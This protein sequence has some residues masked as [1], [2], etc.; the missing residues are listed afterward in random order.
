MITHVE[1]PTLLWAQVLNDSKV[2]EQSQ[3]TVRLAEVCPTAC[4]VQG[5]IDMN[6]V[7]K[8]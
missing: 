8:L 3:I 5:S 2:E 6:K 4:A 7:S 1:T